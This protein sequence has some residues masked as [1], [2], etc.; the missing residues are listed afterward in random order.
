M[1]GRGSW[2][3]LQQPRLSWLSARARSQ[4]ALRKILVQFSE[5][6]FLLHWNVKSAPPLLRARAQPAVWL[7]GICARYFLFAICV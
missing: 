6:V 5:L 1:N 2:T 4:V 3:L 7:C